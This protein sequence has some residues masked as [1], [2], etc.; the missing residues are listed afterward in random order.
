MASTSWSTTSAPQSKLPGIIEFQETTFTTANLE[1]CK[2]AG[3]LVAVL[4]A[5]RHGPFNLN[6]A[7]LY[8]TC[9]VGS[10]KVPLNG[11]EYN[12]QA[13][14][15]ETTDSAL[16]IVSKPKEDFSITIR[17]MGLQHSTITSKDLVVQVSLRNGVSQIGQEIKKQIGANTAEQIL[18]FNNRP[19]WMSDHLFK[20]NVKENSVVKL[21][22]SV[23]LHFWF[24]NTKQYAV[25]T[26]QASLYDA[27]RYSSDMFVENLDDLRFL[28][29]K[30]TGT[31]IPS[32]T[33]WITDPLALFEAE[34]AIGTLEENGLWGGSEIQVFRL[35]PK[36]KAIDETDEQAT[37]G[38]KRQRPREHSFG[39]RFPRRRSFMR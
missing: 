11:P 1:G 36:R 12:A 13:V 33:S 39:R 2:T 30:R 31:A 34:S 28:I 35:H 37:A 18:I 9:D 17:R 29:S 21:K 38:R 16:K 8:T 26:S 23:G 14:L 22:L 6:S 32:V 27:L 10:A 19:M 24:R 3:D 4:K 5:A 20:Y 25:F 15:P 7:S